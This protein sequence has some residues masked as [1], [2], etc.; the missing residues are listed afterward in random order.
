MPIR[1]WVIAT[2]MLVSNGHVQLECSIFSP[3][4][5]LPFRKLGGEEGRGLENVGAGRGGDEKSVPAQCSIS[6]SQTPI[7]WCFPGPARNPCARL[8]PW[9]SG[10]PQLLLAAPCLLPVVRQ[11]EAPFQRVLPDWEPV[12]TLPLLPFCLGPALYSL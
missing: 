9:L 11:W 5:S 10:I 6:S 2:G 7:R 1:S 3:Q 12:A 8:V 4:R